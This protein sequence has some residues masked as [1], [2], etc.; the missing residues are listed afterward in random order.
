MTLYYSTLMVEALVN[1][2]DYETAL[3]TIN[4][5][6]KSCDNHVTELHIKALLGLRKID[7]AKKVCISA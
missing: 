5:E 7:E 2:E 6:L 4:R 1:T 3:N